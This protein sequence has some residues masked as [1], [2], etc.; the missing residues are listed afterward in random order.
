MT[1]RKATCQDIPT[2]DEVSDDEHNP[3]ASIVPPYHS[4]RSSGK[5]RS[6]KRSHSDSETS[7]HRPKRRGQR[8]PQKRKKAKKPCR[9]CKRGPKV[10]DDLDEECYL[11]WGRRTKP[12]LIADGDGDDTLLGGLCFACEKTIAIHPKYKNLKPSELQGILEAQEGQM[13]LESWRQGTIDQL[14]SKSDRFHASSMTQGTVQVVT[15]ATDRRNKRG[16][17]YTMAKWHELTKDDATLRAKRKIVNLKNRFGKMEQVVRIYNDEEGVR[18]FSE[19][20]EETVKHVKVID[21][22]EVILEPNQQRA[23]FED[24]G[25]Q[26]L[27]AMATADN[28]TVKDLERHLKVR[29]ETPPNRQRAITLDSGSEQEGDSEDTSASDDVAPA[30][31]AFAAKPHV[32]PRRDRAAGSSTK[33]PPSAAT[34][35]GKTD[36]QIVLTVKSLLTRHD[37]MMKK[38][39]QSES[40]E[41]VA[42]QVITTL[43]IE[44]KAAQKKCDQ[45]KMQVESANVDTCTRQL[46]DVMQIHRS[47]REHMKKRTTVS[48]AAVLQA[49][50]KAKSVDPQ[51]LPTYVHVIMHAE[52]DLLGAMGAGD[53]DHVLS[54]VASDKI[55][56]KCTVATDTDI[57]GLQKYYY[58]QALTEHLRSST[59]RGLEP[60]MYASELVA[61]AA[62]AV[63][64]AHTDSKKMLTM[65]DTMCRPHDIDATI[66][67]TTLEDLKTFRKHNDFFKAFCN[68]AVGKALIADAEKYV[69]RRD[70]ETQCHEVLS[71]SKAQLQKLHDGFLK[72]EKDK[73][74][75]AVDGHAFPDISSVCIATSQAVTAIDDIPRE[76]MIEAAPL[77]AELLDWCATVYI[78]FCQTSAD[79]C[80]RRLEEIL[81]SA[82]VASGDGV[83]QLQ[84]FLNHQKR[85][86]E[87]LRKLEGANKLIEKLKVASH[88]ECPEVHA[89]KSKLA[90]LDSAVKV[91]R[92]YTAARLLCGDDGS[93]FPTTKTKECQLVVQEF[94]LIVS[95]AVACDLTGSSGT[96]IDGETY[97]TYFAEVITKFLDK[98]RKAMF[99]PEA[100]HFQKRLMSALLFPIGTSPE[101]FFPN[102]N[103]DDPEFFS[104]CSMHVPPCERGVGALA[105]TTSDVHAG[106]KYTVLASL[107]RCRVAAAQC[108][109][110]VNAPAEDAVSFVD[111]LPQ[112]FGAFSDGLKD[113]EK[114][115]GPR[116]DGTE[117]DHPVP[118]RALLE[119]GKRFRD[120][121]SESVVDAWSD[122]LAAKQTELEAVLPTDW[123]KWSLDDPQEAEMMSEMLVTGVVLKVSQL[124]SDLESVHDMIQTE[125]PKINYVF[126]GLNQDA[127][128]AISNGIKDCKQFIAAHAAWKYILVKSKQ[129]GITAQLKK[130]A[131]RDTQARIAKIKLPAS[132]KLPVALDKRVKASAN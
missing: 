27:P 92:A 21:D 61:L 66:V 2:K 9:G 22:G 52:N 88:T 99:D 47:A 54:E 89:Q 73:A 93:S 58:A 122:L 56:A 3:V 5:A 24:I 123:K 49:V 12:R 8:G 57:I 44:L 64:T 36:P 38:Y 65:C 87:S 71:Q 31:M 13:E 120:E 91:L 50:R 17:E 62:R 19:G 100:E 132:H 33:A 79:D 53:F 45:Y 112:C 105:S 51:A 76:Q 4:S 70:K 90:K 121:R 42:E 129:D 37:D 46:S 75:Q 130:Q 124:H 84:D 16:K 86:V 26:V 15:A 116:H 107:D 34:P 119:S 103:V 125:D 128:Q 111:G 95:N 18:D 7:G 80:N 43:T 104:K 101:V 63:R 131:C 20:E 106:F 96:P 117:I 81:G 68:N 29:A 48:L 28:A 126:T 72:A 127:M 40:V 110:A 32:R 77:K 1:K 60:E 118:L 85:S 10:I 41:G 98:A 23:S 74:D 82:H 115:L 30:Q 94:A 69:A 114:F 102:C 14:R 83:A 67:S 25:A 78:E 97:K 55:N 59:K 6:I 109:V 108:Q 11:R 39:K 35:K 113:L